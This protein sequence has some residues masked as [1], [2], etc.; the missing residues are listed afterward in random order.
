MSAIPKNE[1][2]CSIIDEIQVLLEEKRTS[3][4]VMRTGIAIFIVQMF[5]F[6]FLIATSRSYHFLEVM[7][8][9]IPF[10]IINA[11]LMMLAYYLIIFSLIRIRRHDRTITELKKRHRR[12][13]ELM[14]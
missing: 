2:E 14:D 1:N 9:T 10:Y 7:H 3:L 8:L 13:A 5:I 12:V 4:S 6:G 11:C